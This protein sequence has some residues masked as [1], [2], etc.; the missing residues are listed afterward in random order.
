LS[1]GAN[2]HGRRDKLEKEKERRKKEDTK[3]YID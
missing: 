3:I 2:A 1:V